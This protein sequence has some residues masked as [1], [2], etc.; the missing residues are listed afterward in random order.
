MITDEQWMTCLALVNNGLTQKDAAI[1][2]GISEATFYNKCTNDA[3]FKEKL[4]RSRIQFKLTHIQ[5]IA[6]KSKITWQAS[7]WLLERMFRDEFGKETKIEHSMQPFTHIQIEQ[8]YDE[9]EEVKPENNENIPK[10]LN[11]KEGHSS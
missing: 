6:E 1:R 2:A 11:G 9:Y 3:E 5:N 8:H 4:L 10:E 7:A